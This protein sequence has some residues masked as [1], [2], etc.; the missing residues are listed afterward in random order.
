MPFRGRDGEGNFS[1]GY[2]RKPKG[3][4]RPPVV[5]IWGGIDAYK[6]ERQVDLYLAGGLATLA[7]DIP[8][9]GEAPLAGSIDAE[10][11]WDDIFDWVA[12]RLDLD[13]QRIAVIGASTGGYWAAKVAHTHRVEFA[14]LSAMAAW[15]TMHS[16]PTGSLKRKSVNTLLS[17]LRAW[18][19]PSVSLPMR[20]G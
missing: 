5:V 15:L 7:V 9:T 3:I 17:W 16:P 6:E 18:P 12:R 8:G 1:I 13:G 19:W 4:A 2:L 11:M 20:S 10:R 14:R